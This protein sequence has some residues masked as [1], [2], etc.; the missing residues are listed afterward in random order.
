MTNPQHNKQRTRLFFEAMQRG[1]A[2]ALADTYC[3]DGVVVTMGNTLISGTRTK[4]EVREFA[5]GVLAAFPEGLE[6]EIK[7]MTAE[8][9]RVAVEAVSSGRHV[10]GVDYR[11]A[12]HFLLI[13]REDGLQELKEY[14]D[15]E[16]VTK[17]LCGGQ[18][19]E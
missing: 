6:F 14:M 8:E 9:D 19:P 10:S 4:E 5:S 3:R 17:V 16:L 11:N 12:Y 18:S 13:W 15:T 7:T 2:D 1:D